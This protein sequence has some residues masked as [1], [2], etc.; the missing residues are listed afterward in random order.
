MAKTTP[1]HSTHVSLD[2]RMIDFGGWDMPIQYEGI[3]S[4]CATT[5]QRVGIFDI[6]HMGRLEFSGPQA[7]EALDYCV[8]CNVAALTDG[9]VK[10]GLILT[11]RGTAI[12]DVLVYKDIDRVHVV[13]NA[14]N[15]DVDREHFRKIVAE[16]GFDCLVIDAACPQEPHQ[17]HSFLGVPQTML[18]LQ[19][20]NSETLLQ[21]VVNTDTVVSELRYYRMM[22][23]TILGLNCLVSRTGY[24]GE[25][26]FEIF[27]DLRE[28]QRMW[29]L[30]LSQ[31]EDLGI[32]PVGLGARDTLR[33]EAGMPLYGNEID[34]ETTPIEAGLR[35][36]VALKGGDYIGKSV[37]ADQVENGVSKKL[38][39]LE[40]D[41]RRV[42]RQG[43]ALMDGETTLG[44]VTSGTFAPTLDKNIAMGFVPPSH[45]EVGTTFEVDIR[46]KRHGCTVVPMP[47]YK[48]SK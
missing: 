29:D 5:R 3:V 37:L 23:T 44:A 28:A 25:D 31:G 12:D 41:T 42:P 47:F 15:R 21:R 8:S 13:V 35:F 38:V 17:G 46:G 43:C 26:G 30:L 16:K 1:L 33:T 39:G 6:G 40:V 11:E 32:S 48:R 45:A 18:A 22:R 34:L 36:G 2:A 14:G 10:Y 9:R 24:T 7:V 27:F 4:E 19:G 20:P